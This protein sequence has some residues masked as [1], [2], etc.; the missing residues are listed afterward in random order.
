MDHGLPENTLYSAVKVISIFREKYADPPKDITKQGTGF[1]I[2]NKKGEFCLVTNR[3]VFDAHYKPDKDYSLEEYELFQIQVHLKFADDQKL[4]TQDNT[5]VIQ[6]GYLKFPVSEKND[7]ATLINPMVRAYPHPDPK[8]SYQIPYSFL[9]SENDKILTGDMVM[10]PGFPEWHDTSNNRPIM[11]SGTISSDPRFNYEN[12]T[13][14]VSGDCIAYEAFSYGGS[15]G[16]PVFAVQKS[17]E[18]SARLEN[19]RFRRM[20]LVGINAGHLPDKEIRKP[21]SSEV[22]FHTHSGISYMYKASIIREVIDRPN[23]DD[24]LWEYKG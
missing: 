22:L 18:V 16:S 23:S 4:P 7:V 20:C 19:P 17:I 21:N 9:M 1:F 5:F 2:Q 11:R 14:G 13:Y 8:I 12:S 10:F 3:H 6:K 24:A 15:S